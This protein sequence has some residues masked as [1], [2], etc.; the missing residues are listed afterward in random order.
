MSSPEEDS[1]VP[2]QAQGP[3]GC[4]AH[5]ANPSL[6]PPRTPPIQVKE[7][8]PG[9]QFSVRTSIKGD[10]SAR[11]LTIP[12]HAFLIVCGG[13]LLDVWRGTLDAFR[14][15]LGNRPELANA[16]EPA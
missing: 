3:P 11:D 16:I 6:L 15:F 12:Q 1:R 2:P 13:A 14:T 4:F 9:L 8:I 5:T 7:F 10:L